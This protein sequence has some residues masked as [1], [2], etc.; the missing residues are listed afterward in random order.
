MRETESRLSNQ[1]AFLFKRLASVTTGG[2]MV[3]LKSWATGLKVLTTA[4][5]R[6]VI[7]SMKRLKRVPGR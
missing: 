3:W 2:M 7:R 4:V 6:A 1:A 5:L